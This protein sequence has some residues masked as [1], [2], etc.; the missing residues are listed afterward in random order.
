MRLC[1]TPKSSVTQSKICSNLEYPLVQFFISQEK[2]NIPILEMSRVDFFF[3]LISYDIKLLT[4]Y[5]LCSY[6]NYI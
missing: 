4:L 1:L 2:F 5:L 6:F 3:A